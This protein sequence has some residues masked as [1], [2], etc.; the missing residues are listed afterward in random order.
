MR[1]L[2]RVWL[3]RLCG[4]FWLSR[5]L[6]PAENLWPDIWNKGSLSD[7]DAGKKETAADWRPAGNQVVTRSPRLDGEHR[8]PR[9]IFK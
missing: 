5:R 8:N 2:S 7:E 1:K 9:L 6:A 3:V 4:Y